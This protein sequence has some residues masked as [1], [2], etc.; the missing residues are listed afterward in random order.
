MRV[1]HL[2][3]YK[4][5]MVNGPW[6][7]APEAMKVA[8]SA[9]VT[10]FAYTAYES[11]TEAAK[12]RQW[13]KVKKQQQAAQRALLADA[14]A[15]YQQLP[16]GMRALVD[17]AAAAQRELD[18]LGKGYESF[19]SPMDQFRSGNLLKAG[20]QTTAS[21]KRYL[22]YKPGDDWRL[23]LIDTFMDMWPLYINAK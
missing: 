11:T 18:Q 17:A 6:A 23:F 12:Y 4:G 8:V 7:L 3:I 1:H 15:C 13:V 20:V 16:S 21:G 19:D 22:A 10:N 2:E 14:Q 5:A 9:G